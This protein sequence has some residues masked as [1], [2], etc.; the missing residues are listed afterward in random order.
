MHLV[1]M[2]LDNRAGPYCED[3]ITGHVMEGGL[4]REMTSE[5]LGDESSAEE[6]EEEARKARHAQLLR[7][8]CQSNGLAT[9]GDHAKLE[10]RLVAALGP[11]EAIEREQRD[12]D[13][14]VAC[15][16]GD[17]VWIVSLYYHSVSGSVFVCVPVEWP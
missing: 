3:C 6:A 17:M 8:L 14:N 13:R 10:Q 16:L 12:T 5:E 4:C 15:I 9:D 2:C 11:L 7:E 1:E